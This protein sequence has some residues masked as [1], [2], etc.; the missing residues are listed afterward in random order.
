MDSYYKHHSQIWSMYQNC[1]LLLLWVL[2][3][4]LAIL[5]I[6]LY[7]LPSQVKDFYLL[8]IWYTLSLS[9]INIFSFVNESVSVHSQFHPKLFKC[10]VDINIPINKLIWLLISIQNCCRELIS[11]IKY[12]GIYSWCALHVH[13]LQCFFSSYLDFFLGLIGP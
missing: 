11:P 13:D 2:I 8:P 3:K 1:I 10:C 7:S 4:K 9:L 12:L 5:K 6:Y